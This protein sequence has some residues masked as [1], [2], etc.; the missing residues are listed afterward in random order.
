MNTG[1]VHW[2]WLLSYLLAINILAFILFA[3]DKRKAR[4]HGHRLPEK[5][6]LFP[7]FLGG[8]VGALLAMR[9][10]RHKTK[11]PRF[12][13]GLPLLLLAQLVLVFLLLDIHLF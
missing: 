10:L 13:W 3:V 6:L 11:K 1:M 2:L 4:H 7:A 5:A 12:R 9:L 8:S